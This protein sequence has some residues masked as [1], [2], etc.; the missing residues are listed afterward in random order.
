MGAKVREIFN[1][2]GSKDACGIKTKK[3]GMK[4][5]EKAFQKAG[6]ERDVIINKSG[7]DTILLGDAALSTRPGLGAGQSQRS[8]A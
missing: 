6:N 8:G 5:E 3:E 7:F 1:I 2:S 4:D